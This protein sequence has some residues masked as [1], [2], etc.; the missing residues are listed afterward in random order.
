MEHFSVISPSPKKDD[1]FFGKQFDLVISMQ[2]LYYLNDTDLETRLQSLYNQMNTGAYIYVSMVGEQCY[3]YD[4]ST[5]AEDGVRL[6]EF[7][8]G[9]YQMDS[10]CMSFIKDKE[11]LI[12]K[13]SLFEKL[14][15][16][17]YD[18][19]YLESEGSEYHYTFIGRKA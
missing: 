14:H 17:F 5:A 4:N 11:Q 15:V 7:N 12:E 2:V 13:F 9:R 19:Q 16:G 6:V 1:N 18:A 10:H 8:N 3:W